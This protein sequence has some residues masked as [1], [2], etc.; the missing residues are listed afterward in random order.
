[1]Q[2]G[3]DLRVADT[4]VTAFDELYRLI[5]DLIFSGG[6][7]G[8]ENSFGNTQKQFI[9]KGIEMVDLIFPLPESR[10]DARFKRS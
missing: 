1:V 2:F 5:Y 10:F 4:A 9:D 7:A 8:I 3:G 6:A